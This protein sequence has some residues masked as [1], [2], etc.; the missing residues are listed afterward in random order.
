MCC[1]FL[2]R[3]G[4][5]VRILNTLLTSERG[6]WTMSTNKTEHLNLHS[7]VRSDRFNMDEVNENFSKLD[8][9]AEE[10]SSKID[11]AIGD[12]NSK[13]DKAVADANSKIDSA[14]A[15]TNSKIDS[16]VADTNSKITKAVSDTNTALAKKAETTAL[17]SLETRLT[18]AQG[19]IP[20]VA[21]GTYSGTGTGAVNTTVTLGFKPKAVL[22]ARKDHSFGSYNALLLENA[23]CV[24][25]VHTLGQITASGFM[26]THS[27]SASPFLNYGD[28]TYC[29]LAVG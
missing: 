5:G 11:Q 10:N 4:A 8:Q 14:I 15:D 23:P 24:N 25:G 13:F 20:K 1:K 27:S 26:T 28:T 18:T 16:A 21:I 29:Y 3:G 7:W 17:Q 2:I 9:A 12:T 22:I 6:F 19:T